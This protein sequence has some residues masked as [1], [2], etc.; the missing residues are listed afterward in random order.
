MQKPPTTIMIMIIKI[1]II[2]NN[3]NL[4]FITTKLTIKK[5]ILFTI[6]FTIQSKHYLHLSFP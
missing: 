1:I 6:N 4:L 3:P 5:K 2:I